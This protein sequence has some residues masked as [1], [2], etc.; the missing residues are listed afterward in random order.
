MDKIKNKLKTKPIVES[1]KFFVQLGE[2][3]IPQGEGEVTIEP[4]IIIDNTDKQFDDSKFLAL[5]P[6]NLSSSVKDTTEAIVLLP[7]SFAI[8]SAVPFL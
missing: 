6:T 1:N 5:S 8:I 4:T 7:S 3:S 2:E